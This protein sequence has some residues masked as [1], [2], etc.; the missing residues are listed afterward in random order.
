MAH[1][2]V[3]PGETLDAETLRAHCAERLAR[4]KVPEEFVFVDDFA[5]TP[6]GKIRK[7]DLR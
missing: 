2:Q 7:V 3:A 4:Y 5:Y 1:V 6:M